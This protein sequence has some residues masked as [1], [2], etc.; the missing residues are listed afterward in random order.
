MQAHEYQTLYEFESTYWWFVGLHGILRDTLHRLGVGEEDRVLDAGCGTGQNLRILGDKVSR[1][2]YGFDVSSEAAKFW[3]RRNLDRAV[4]ASVNE[5]P[6]AS[7][8][9]EAVVCVDVFECNGVRETDAFGEIWRVLKPNGYA[10][11]VAP[12]YKWL[13]TPEH[14]Q[15]VG[16]GRRYTRGRLRT[17]LEQRPVEV[18][19]VTHL[20]AT[21]LPAIAAYRLGLRMFRNS[22]MEEPPRSELKPMSKPLNNLFFKV[23]EAERILLRSINLPFG[24]SILAVC[25]K[26]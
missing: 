2:S 11:I 3:S 13:M 10:L 1:H 16:A 12:A 21:L 5:I 18:I 24:S 17:I 9:F 20:F 8:S 6:F 14:H 15:A 7:E 23:V 4:L 25:R 26:V 22:K 19:R